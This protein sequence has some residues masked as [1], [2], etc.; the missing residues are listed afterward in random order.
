MKTYTP[1]AGDLE[2]KWFVVDAENQI[3]GRL[4][5]RIAMVLRGKNDPRFAPHANMRNHVIVVNADKIRMTGNKWTDKVFHRHTG[6]I[7]NLKSATA[8][9]IHAKKPT[10]LLRMAVR[11]M[12]PHNRLGRQMMRQLRLVAG[13]EHNHKAQKPVVLNLSKTS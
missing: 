13:P 9:R 6:W 11:G 1:K 4:A 5:S 12:I 7:G 8:E 2:E 3:L 10:E